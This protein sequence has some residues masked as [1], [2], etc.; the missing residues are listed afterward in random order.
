M[1][2]F[3]EAFA[4]KEREIYDANNTE[5]INL[6]REDTIPH[7]LDDKIAKLSI[8]TN[9]MPSATKKLIA[10]EDRFAAVG[11]AKDTSKQNWR[12]EFLMEWIQPYP[13]VF[14]IDGDTITSSGGGQNKKREG[15]QK[16]IDDTI[17]ETVFVMA[18][19]TGWMPEG[20]DRVTVM[21]PDEFKTKYN[22]G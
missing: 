14:E 15:I 6:V 20:N 7:W 18:D 12:K 1:L 4:Q 22:K 3:W 9:T 11:V 10:N 17:E 19:D 21:T 2:T 13:H 8:K 5:V 16:R